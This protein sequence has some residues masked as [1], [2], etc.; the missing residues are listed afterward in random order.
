[1]NA[2]RRLPVLQAPANE[3]VPQ[4]PPWQWSFFGGGLITLLWVVLTQVVAPLTRLLAASV[5]ASM[6][7]QFGVQGLASFLVGTVIGSWGPGR[8]IREG[9]WAGAISALFAAACVVV[10]ASAGQATWM[11]VLVS[12]AGGIALIPSATLAGALGAWVGSRKKR[13]LT[14][15]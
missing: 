9:A 13:V 5:I 12:A 4:R 3:D 7:L 8:G 11:D 14:G 1:M 2:K 10:V 6:L 15:D